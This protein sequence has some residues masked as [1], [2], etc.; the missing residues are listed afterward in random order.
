M[1]L[2]SL[3]I[4]PGAWHQPAH[5]RRFIDEL[6]DV[7][8][9][10]VALTTCGDDVTTLGDLF[11]DAA[12]I[13]AAAHAIDGPVVVLAHSYGGAPTTQAL[14]GASN[15]RRIIYLTAFQLDVGESL[16]SSV[17]DVPPPWWVIH[18]HDGDARNYMTVDNP[19]DVFYG[20]VDAALTEQAIAGLGYQCY[21]ATTQELTQAA[22]KDIPSTYILCEA[23]N[24]IPLFGQELFAKRSEKVLRLDTSHS[25]FLSQPAALARLIKDELASV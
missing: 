19:A 3:L 17:G 20:D 16:L 14:V 6:G 4:V 9:H 21:A 2:P 23:D 25:P 13:R 8:V 18:E 12:A 7:D 15:V 22:W 11:S 1:T 10:A 24:A 5:F